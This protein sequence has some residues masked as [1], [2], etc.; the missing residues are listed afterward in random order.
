MK[1]YAERMIKNWTV[2]RIGLRREATRTGWRIQRNME[3]HNFCFPPHII[4]GIKSKSMKG[5]GTCSINAI[6]QKCL[7]DF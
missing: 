6:N 2:K 1:K 3:L 7:Q 5:A 4:T